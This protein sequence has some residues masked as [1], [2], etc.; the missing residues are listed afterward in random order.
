MAPHVTLGKHTLP[1]PAQPWPVVCDVLGVD[2]PSELL[3]RGEDVF[4]A[5]RGRFAD[6]PFRDLHGL[7]GEFIPTLPERLPL[8]EWSGYAS[9][10]AMEAGE[11][12]RESVRL[13]PDIDQIAAAI[14]AIIMV[15]GGERVGKLLGLAQQAQALGASVQSTNGLHAGPISPVS[16]GSTGG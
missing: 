10:E 16:P 7:L 4:A 14:E 6:R 3:T 11:R 2:D 12:T 8:H 15:N 13:A 9:P 1:C 5:L